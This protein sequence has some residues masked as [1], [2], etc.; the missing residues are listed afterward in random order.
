MSDSHD[1][2]N[3][4]SILDEVSMEFSALPQDI[5]IKMILV[6]D[7]L[8]DS[9]QIFSDHKMI[10][11][12]YISSGNVKILNILRDQMNRLLNDLNTF[13]VANTFDEDR[14][15]LEFKKFI[16]VQQKLRYKV[17]K[18][19]RQLNMNP[20]MFNWTKLK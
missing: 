12:D 3:I 16:K 10:A 1:M 6:C 11:S 9:E 18:A 13:L 17:D 5:K 2:R 4:L 20:P 7:S 8:S 19:V 14:D 15:V